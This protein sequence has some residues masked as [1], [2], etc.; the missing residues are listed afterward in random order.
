[1]VST[2]YTC[3]TY[4][5]NVI[6]LNQYEIIKD[7]ITVYLLVDVF[8]A[9]KQIEFEILY[10]IYYIIVIIIFDRQIIHSV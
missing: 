3:L 8:S 5:Y 2:C 10:M 1:M 6:Y 4:H 7:M 9:A